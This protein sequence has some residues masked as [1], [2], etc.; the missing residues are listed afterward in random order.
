MFPRS[1][2]DLSISPDRTRL[3]GKACDMVDEFVDLHQQVHTNLEAASTKYNAAVDVH[4]C[5]LQFDVGDKVWAVL[6][7][8]RFSVGTYN[9]LKPRK[10]GLLDIIEKVNNNAYRLRFPLHM[11]TADD[12]NMKHLVPYVDDIP[13]V[14]F[15]N[16]FLLPRET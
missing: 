5:E 9:K 14:E 11:K 15:E 4:R 3:H 6:T 13:P 10:I 16:K 12:F 2:L 8:D 1:L 7:K